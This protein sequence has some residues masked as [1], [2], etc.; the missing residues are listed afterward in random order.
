MEDED[1]DGKKTIR[2]VQEQKEI[3]WEVRKFYHKLYSEKEAKVDKIEIL[4][5]IEEVTQISDVDRCKL[6]CGSLKEK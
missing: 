4:Q 1:K 3:E 2:I 5:N 6:E